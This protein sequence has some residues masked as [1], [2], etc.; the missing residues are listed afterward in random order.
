MAELLAFQSWTL[1]SYHKW[2]IECKEGS[3]ENFSW[4]SLDVYY[5][6]IY[7]QRTRHQSMQDNDTDSCLGTLQPQSRKELRQL[8]HHPCEPSERWTCY[9]YTFG[10]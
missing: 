9:I 4:A 5:R 2:Q 6:Y 10:R 1:E 8:N 7:I 3:L